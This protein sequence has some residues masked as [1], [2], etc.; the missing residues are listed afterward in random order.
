M[1]RVGGNASAEIGSPRG[2]VVSIKKEWAAAIAAYK[3]AG[4][5]AERTKEQRTR[6]E[7]LRSYGTTFV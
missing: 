2:I 4:T 7:R 1:A 3:A 5:D 6:I